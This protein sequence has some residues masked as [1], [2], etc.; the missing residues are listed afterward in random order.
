M[1]NEGPFIVEWVAWYKMLGFK[2]IVVVTNNCTD[3]SPQ[4]LDALQAAGWLYHLR[5]DVPPGNPI[6]PAKLALAK[7]HPR[8]RRANWVLVCDVDEFLVIHKGGGLLTDLVGTGDPAFLGMSIN[9]KVFGTA[10]IDQFHDE[11][12]HRQFFA[13]NAPNRGLSRFVKSV[14]RKPDWFKIMGEHGPRRLDLA[15]AGQAWGAP[16]MAWVNA[17]GDVV[18]RWT[19]DG[20]YVRM[21]GYEDGA[22]EVAQMNHY[23]LRSVETYSLKSGTLSPVARTERYSPKYFRMA[24]R[25]DEIDTSALRYAAAFEARQAAAM[26]LPDVARLHY[27]CCADHLRL[28]AEKLGHDITADPRHAAFLENARA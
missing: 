4:L 27:Q 3:H 6:T 26:A 20:E 13:A 25:A 18:P 19:P 21:I 17:R 8:V 23:M 2:N 22:H 28:I 12:V 5:H 16:G 10:G 14:F 11:P 9:W 15:A 7:R 1:R 24:N